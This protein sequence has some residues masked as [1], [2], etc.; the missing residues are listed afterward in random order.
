MQVLNIYVDMFSARK[1]IIL[2]IL[3][4]SL[5]PAVQSLEKLICRPKWKGSA[6]KGRAVAM[7]HQ[8]KGPLAVQE[9]VGGK[10][11]MICLR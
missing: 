11:A 4:C 3:P 6:R 9:S 8:L 2:L 7:P 1:A 5:L 10:L